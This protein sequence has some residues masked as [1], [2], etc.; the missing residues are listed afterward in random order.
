MKFSKNILLAGVGALAL[1]GCGGGNDDVDAPKTQSSVQAEKLSAASP[2][3]TKFTL[4]GGSEFD[5][6]KFLALLPEDVRPSYGSADFDSG[7]GATVVQNLR[8]ADANDGEA[9]II[10]RAEFFGVDE[11]AID[12][13]INAG[14]VGTDG[15][16]ETVFQKVRLINISSAGFEDE[17][18]GEQL[19][20]SIAGVEFDELRM[21]QGGPE[22]DPAG[23]ELAGFVNAISLG[24]LYFKDLN[25]NVMGDET[26]SINLSAP[27]MRL[28]GMAGGKVEAIL[29]KDLSY[30]VAQGEDTRAAL[31]ESMGPQGGALLDGP[32]GALIAPDSQ[33]VDM[34]SFEWRNIDFSGLVKY[35]LTGEEPPASDRDLIDL[36]SMAMSD[37]TAYLDGR[38]VSTMG[39]VNVP[40]MAFA[41]LIPSDFR[42]EFKDA[43]TDYTAYIPDTED[44]AYAVLAERGLNEVPADGFFNWTWSPDSGAGVLDY[45]VTSP[46]LADFS[47][48]FAMTGANLKALAQAQEDGDEEVFAKN[49]ALKSLNLKIKD[50]TALDAIFAL[51]ALELGGTGDDLRQSAPALLRLSGSQVAQINPRINGYIDAMADFVANGGSLEI[52]ATPE[53]PLAAAAFASGEVTPPTLPD[54]LDLKITHQ[55]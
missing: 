47:M 23:E 31:R 9:I 18:S 6:D 19:D 52:S 28:V 41:W 26:L 8:F 38:K 16:Y 32:L 49:M 2:L 20:L 5:V 54:V 15:P 11:E 44:P 34:S 4:K 35:G 3:D 7:L 37:M 40:K 50:E 10:E 24:G 29:A 46:G 36:G 14:D 51:A 33:R 53:E 30:D 45:D 25:F 17:D 43:V 12:R 21:R 1:A 39:E 42:M 22:G 13:I 27:D 55:E 48:N